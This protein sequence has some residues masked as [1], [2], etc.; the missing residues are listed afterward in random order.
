MALLDLLVI[1]SHLIHE[2]HL[3]AHTLRW[4]YCILT[5][6]TSHDWFALLFAKLR[7]RGALSRG[8]RAFHLV[9]IRQLL[10]CREG[11]L[12]I[13]WHSLKLRCV[14]AWLNTLNASLI[15]KLIDRVNQVLS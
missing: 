9:L 4:H 8:G 1:E 12:I 3:H 10:F 14:N 13:L 7:S 2:I 6:L 11:T 15:L 5:M